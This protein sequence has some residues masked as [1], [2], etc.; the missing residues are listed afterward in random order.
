MLGAIGNVE[1]RT[2]PDHPLRYPPLFVVGPP[3]S[4]TTLL[5]QVISYALDVS[6]IPTFRTDLLTYQTRPPA[7]L[8][9]HLASAFRL[10]RRRAVFESYYGKAKGFGHAADS[11]SIIW[12]YVFPEGY[13]DGENLSEELKR[14]VHKTIAGVERVFN[15]PFV[16]KGVGHS[17]RIRAL[18]EIFPNA[19]FI[20]SRRDPL[21]VAQSV[22]IGRNRSEA[23][24]RNWITPKARGYLE[25]SQK[26]LVEQSCG[27]QHIFDRDIDEGLAAVPRERQLDVNYADLC[28]NPQD[29]V[30]KIAAFMNRNGAE[31]RQINR[32][33]ESFPLS[34]SRRVDDE[35]YRNLV[36]HVERIYGPDF[37]RLEEPRKPGETDGE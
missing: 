23:T 6:Y 15:K 16:D 31:T 18:A 12:N 10:I 21:A 3:R 33:P 35:T 13:L 11:G 36:E 24:R 30:E 4:G 20:R 7:V 34:N 27:Q 25:L 14:T 9:T 1:A 5:G 8:L 29:E 32:V 22:Y 2:L 17:I 28:A 37:E 26:S 19:L